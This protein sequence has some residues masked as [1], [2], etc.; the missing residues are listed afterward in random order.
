MKL[1]RLRDAAPALWRAVAPPVGRWLIDLATICSQAFN[2][3]ILR[4]SVDET[5]SARCH[6]L[7]DRHPWGTLRRII[8]ALFFWQPDHC[9]SSY[10]DDVARAKVYLP[11]Q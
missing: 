11:L 1:V 8:N 5:V 4:G 6:R 7:R 3:L 2:A 10:A 9:A